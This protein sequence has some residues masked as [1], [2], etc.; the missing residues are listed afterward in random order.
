MVLENLP[1]ES[2]R[3][4]VV[5]RTNVN[6]PNPAIE[7]FAVDD[8]L[9]TFVGR[10]ESPP[11]VHLW[12]HRNTVV[13]GALDTR[14][15]N[16]HKGVDYLKENGY[17]VVVRNSGGAAVVLDPGVLNISVVLPPENSGFSINAG[18]EYLLALIKKLLGHLGEKVQ[19]G[20]IVGSYCP[21]SYDVSV[22][23]KKFGGMAQRR[24]RNAVAVQAFILVDGAGS[25]RAQLIRGFYDRA[26]GDHPEAGDYPHVHVDTMASLVE[27]AE[28][29]LDT[30]DMVTLK[31]RLFTLLME[32]AEQ[33]FVGTGVMTQEVDEFLANL[34][35]MNTRNRL[36]DE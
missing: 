21:G 25:E 36:L 18:Y 7:S 16:F 12:V 2:V 26:A 32:Q 19:A 5:D 10:G 6:I 8:T 1:F 3:W 17:D 9:C 24:R 11:A 31:N 20:E 33:V 34:Q 35:G 15:P 30:W 29:D 23:G 13:L 14:L 27:L 22:A 4:R 28:S